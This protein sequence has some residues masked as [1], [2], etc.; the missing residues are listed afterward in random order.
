MRELFLV[1]LGLSLISGCGKKSEESKSKSVAHDDMGYSK[2]VSAT[3]ALSDDGTYRFLEQNDH[4]S[5]ICNEEFVNKAFVYLEVAKSY[6][7][8]A[9]SKGKY[10]NE[11]TKDVVRHYNSLRDDLVSLLEDWSTSCVEVEA[12]VFEDLEYK[13]G[14]KLR[15][16]EESDNSLI[17]SL[18]GIADYKESLKRLLG[19]AKKG[20]TPSIS[21]IR[22][23]HMY[24]QTLLSAERPIVQW[25]KERFEESFVAIANS[26]PENAH[27]MEPGK[28]KASYEAAIEE[29]LNK[30]IQY[31]RAYYSVPSKILKGKT[32]CLG[33]TKTDLLLNLEVRGKD[34]YD[35]RPVVI[36]STG[37]IQPGYIAGH[38]DEFHLYGVE[39]TAEGEAVVYFG[40]I[41]DIYTSSVL[42]EEI[43]VI[44]A[45][46]YLFFSSIQ[47]YISKPAEAYE[48][49]VARLAGQ[50]G[51]TGFEDALENIKS[52]SLEA[53]GFSRTRKSGQAAKK[54]LAGDIFSFG[55]STQKR[56]T[57]DRAVFNTSSKLDA[58]FVSAEEILTEIIRKN[59]TKRQSAQAS[60]QTLLDKLKNKLAKFDSLSLPTA[61]EKKT[62]TISESELIDAGLPHAYDISMVAVGEYNCYGGDER[63][64]DE[65][66]GKIQIDEMSIRFEESDEI[67]NRTSRKSYGTNYGYIA[68]APILEDG[69]SGHGE[70]YEKSFYGYVESFAVEQY[71]YGKDETSSKVAS[72]ITCRLAR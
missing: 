14:T 46:D 59:E 45:F 33:G 32:Q 57:F 2:V 38:G 10:N 54:S 19:A 40:N 64:E 7:Q 42:E 56:G 71:M 26:L 68:L 29:K 34:Y 55:N 21:D 36:S 20:Q 13:S 65:L 16:R 18:E 24:Q 30:K 15:I 35:L 23:V 66:A 41:K 70:M 12:L 53:P 5:L 39:T 67:L 4:S 47:N 60:V 6:T 69:M 51:A 9:I 43:T 37:H 63:R 1:V 44:D 61:Q 48:K 25:E 17:S 8:K 22:N 52:L 49:L 72:Q 11:Q 31:N 3:A 62:G 58:D 50:Y 28:F 27:V